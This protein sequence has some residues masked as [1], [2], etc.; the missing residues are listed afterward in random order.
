VRI[1]IE[2]RLKEF[3]E[4][5]PRAKGP[6]NSWATAIESS[7]WKNPGDLKRT[8]GMVDFVGE[9]TVFDIGGNKFR[10]I[11]YVHYRRQIVYVKYVLTHAE[12]DKGDWK[13]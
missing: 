4:R 10:L 1:I 3:V 12:Y 13:V 5:F 8:F 6:L 2:R 7:A 11:A 9:K